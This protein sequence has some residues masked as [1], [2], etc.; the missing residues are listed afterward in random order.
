VRPTGRH[1]YL[2]SRRI[3]SGV[4]HSGLLPGHPVWVHEVR[5]RRSDKGEATKNHGQRGKQGQV[6]A[7]CSLLMWNLRGGKGRWSLSARAA[8]HFPEFLGEI[9]T[10]DVSGARIAVGSRHAIMSFVNMG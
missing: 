8:C 10:Q 2:Y 1:T 5:P 4:S 6:T 9:N 7:I 3:A